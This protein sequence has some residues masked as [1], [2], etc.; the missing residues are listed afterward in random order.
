MANL[1]LIAA[2]SSP[3]EGPPRFR[4]KPYRPATFPPPSVK[5]GVEQLIGNLGVQVALNTTCSHLPECAC[6]L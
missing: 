2:A 5:I 4:G 3:R 6:I 1:D